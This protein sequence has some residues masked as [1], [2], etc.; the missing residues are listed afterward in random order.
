MNLV[1]LSILVTAYFFWYSSINNQGGDRRMV[2]K[3]SKEDIKTLERLNIISQI[4]P[5]KEKIKT[6][7]ERYNCSFQEF[8]EEIKREENFKKWDDYI[9]WK[10]YV[11]K[12]K[13]LELSLKEI[14]DAK[15]IE[16]S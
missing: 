5:V 10:A 12:L 15:D 11:E 2:I 16:I 3:I 13:D 9:E 8:E 14:E 1:D 4:A 7:E 6:F